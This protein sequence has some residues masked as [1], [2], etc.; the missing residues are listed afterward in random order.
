VRGTITIVAAVVL[1]AGVLGLAGCSASTMAKSYG[2]PRTPDGRP[3]LNGIWQA[4]TTA[5]LDIQDHSAR[6][7]MAA[8]QGIVDGGEIPYQT[9]A[10]E[11]KKANYERRDRDDPE[12]R[13]Y[14]PGVPRA[15]YLPFPFQIVQNSQNITVAY[16]Y[17]HALRVI[18]TDSSPHEKAAADSWM[19][20]SRGR[21]EGDTLVVDVTGFND[22]T[23]FDRAGNFHSGVL[24]VIE[25]YIPNDRDHI[26]YEA[27]IDDSEVFVRTWKIR[28]PLYRRIEQNVQILDYECVAFLEPE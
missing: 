23:W 3:D 13:C 2:G 25:R 26:T 5:S 1:S 9:W 15:T 28:L 18:P 22:R 12:A 17:A 24:H 27:T 20:D 19:G 16:E 6:L 4:L 8:G 21:W 7:G 14:Q 11:K 10:L